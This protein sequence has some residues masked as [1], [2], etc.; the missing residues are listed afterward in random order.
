[1]KKH[2]KSLAKV[3]GNT[4]LLLLYVIVGSYEYKEN[5]EKRVGDY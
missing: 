5:T 4:L 3:G 2:L 1:M